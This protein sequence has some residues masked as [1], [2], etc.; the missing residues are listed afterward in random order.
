[1]GYNASAY[2]NAFVCYCDHS[3]YYMLSV[4]VSG[5]F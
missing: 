1:M 2:K 5:P 4:Y 3:R